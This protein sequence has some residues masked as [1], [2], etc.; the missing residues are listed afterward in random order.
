[1][2]VFLSA[3][4]TFALVTL[5]CT[6]TPTVPSDGALAAKAKPVPSVV[7]LG[8]T[9]TDGSSYQIQ[10]DGL[11]EYVNGVDGMTVMIDDSGNL[12]ITPANASGTNPP[13]R[14]LN[15]IYP[16]GQTW[17]FPQ[18]LNFKIKSNKTNNGNPRIQDMGVGVSLCYNVT[19]AHRT[20]AV[21]YTDNF[22]PAAF[23]S[24]TY[25]LISRTSATAWTIQSSGMASTGLDCGVDNTAWVT[26]TD[27]TA[28]HGGDF[29]VGAVTENLS[30]ALRALP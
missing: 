29:T 7:L 13:A 12:Q 21:A 18:Q 4:C 3:S 19:I 30:I 28:K 16:P 15:I 5:A 25:A 23:P 8:M 1:M 22:N 27:L 2:R 17:T 26:G 20:A 9:V 14:R 11:G 10:S 6:S 24:S